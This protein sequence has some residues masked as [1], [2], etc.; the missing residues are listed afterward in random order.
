MTDKLPALNKWTI[1]VLRKILESYNNNPD[2][3]AIYESEARYY[4]RDLN[5]NYQD[6]IEELLN[7][8]CLAYSWMQTASIP[9][10]RALR[11]TDLGNAVLDAHKNDDLVIRI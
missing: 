2:M 1:Y 3:F 9:P 5:G 4:V 11:I 7:T 8:K 6:S 10:K